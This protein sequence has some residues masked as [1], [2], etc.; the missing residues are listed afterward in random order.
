[1][2]RRIA[3]WGAVACAG[4]LLALAAMVEAI[5][6][7]PSRVRMTVSAAEIEAEDAH[8][9]GLGLTLP[10]GSLLKARPFEAPWTS[11]SLLTPSTWR[12]PGWKM[13]AAP[14][15]VRA[16]LLLADLDV[17][18]PV[19]ERAYGGW[20][21][22]AA[23]GWNWAR[24]FDDWRGR[25]AARGTAEISDDEAFAPMD[26]LF[27][28][29][30]DNHTQIPLR[31]RTGD[32]SQTAVLARAPGG[33]C[34]E[35][36]AGEGTFAIAAD[37]AGQQ[38]RAARLWRAG[39]AGF[40]ETHYV[41]MPRSRG[42]PQAVLCGGAWIGLERVGERRSG[43]AA[44][45]R[46]LWAETMGRDRAHFERLGDGVAYVR[47]P[48]FVAR[49]YETPAGGWPRREA[50]DRVLIVDLRNNEGNDAEY[51]REVLKGWVDETRIVPFERI[52][53]QINSSCLYA[54]LRWN[55]PI[56]DSM[57]EAQRLLDRM[58]QPYAA[59][60]P[61]TV[62]ARPARWTYLERRFA[63]QPGDLRIVALVNSGCGSDCEW[64]T[65]MLASLPETIVV[66]SN[67]YG[68]FE[69][70]Q[71][72]Y[73]VLPHTGLAYRIA[74]G[75]SDY[76]GDGRSVDGYGLDVD[77]VAPEVDGLGPRE[78][79]ELGEQVAGLRD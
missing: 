72:G 57:A 59:G 74:L 38:V 78:L 4:L 60:C 64:M 10:D 15:R 29:Q 52:G 62:D 63:P 5:A 32:G 49:N 24:W 35:I 41:A 44:V 76:F 14:R 13:L 30:R 20:E 42:A 6:H 22:A 40:A 43:A 2:W 18:Q 23:R 61:R 34:T 50:G 71:P 46:E 77:V 39:A 79:R 45:L 3:W 11:H 53:A 58:A 68:V 21:S 12:E 33:G 37:D 31:R 1:V 55:F 51:G 36:R 65:A 54:P 26:A 7:R 48:T 67:T 66:G 25:L 75:R 17:L 16:D 27:A 47:L 70:I 8:L 28:F 56:R 9:R 73:S 69:N 19:M